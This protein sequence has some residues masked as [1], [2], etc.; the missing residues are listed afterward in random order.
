MEALRKDVEKYPDSYQ[1][2]RAERFGVWQSTIGSA[3]KRLGI[4]Y[5]KNSESS[6][7]G[8]SGTY[9]VPGNNGEV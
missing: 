1:Y 6:E 2:E 7:G 4:S 8:R 5:K 9:T 3:L